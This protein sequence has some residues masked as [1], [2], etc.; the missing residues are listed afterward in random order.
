MY[1]TDVF[2]AAGKGSE[3][4]PAELMVVVR[5][6]VDEAPDNRFGEV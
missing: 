1:C 3:I 2:G 4:V 5:H 6:G